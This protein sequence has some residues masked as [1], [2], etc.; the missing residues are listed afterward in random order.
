MMKDII[1]TDLKELV[2]NLK[3]RSLIRSMVKFTTWPSSLRTMEFY[4]IYYED[5]CKMA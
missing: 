3:G 5:Y 1:T 4:L 2:N